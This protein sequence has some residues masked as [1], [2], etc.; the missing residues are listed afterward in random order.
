MLSPLKVEVRLDNFPLL[1]LKSTLSERHVN[2]HCD[3][4][5]KDNVN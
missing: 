4:L 2:K 5:L 3:A 1:G